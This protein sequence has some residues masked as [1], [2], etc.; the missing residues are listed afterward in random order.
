MGATAFAGSTRI[1][2]GE[3][4]KVVSEAKQSFDR[5]ETVLVF[6]DATGEVVD[7]DHRD[8]A[9][10]SQ[11]A[12][13]ER[14]AG[15]PKLGVVP[16]EVTLLPRHWEWLNA[17]PGGASASLRRLVEQAR[18]DYVDRDR[19]RHSQEA[20]HRFMS[21]MAGN[22]PGYEEA[23]RAL[24]RGD[25]ARFDDCVASWPADVRQYASALG[26][27]ALGRAV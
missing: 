6:N 1:A 2:A 14:R 23:L 15:R 3:L 18:R 5:G 21:A 10:T 27:A 12:E 25:A 16:R 24:F 22:E 19:V 7:L 8:R 20:A 13:P 11:D 17:Q 4:R 9:E 26:A